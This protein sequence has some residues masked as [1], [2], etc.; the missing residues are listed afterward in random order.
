VKFSQSTLISLRA[1]LIALLRAVDAALLEGY[2]WTPRCKTDK[3]YE[4]VI[5]LN[6]V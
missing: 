4:S 5:D 1:A 2:G 3:A 6:M